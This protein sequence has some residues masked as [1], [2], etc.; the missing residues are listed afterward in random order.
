[1]K[2]CESIPRDF[3]G[4]NSFLKGIRPSIDLLVIHV[5]ADISR[6]SELNCFTPC[7]PA[8][9]MVKNVKAKIMQ[10]LNEGELPNH[11]MCCIPCDN[12][13]AWVLAAYDTNSQ[14]HNPPVIFLECVEKPDYIISDPRKRFRL[15]KRKDGK[16][17]DEK[18]LSGCIDTAGF[19]EMGSG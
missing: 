18:G 15:L 9:E 1:M 8:E 14:Y 19:G 2:W 7:P 3:G 12:T 11:I 6:E 16:P 5:D 10:W 4:I 17:K 13:E